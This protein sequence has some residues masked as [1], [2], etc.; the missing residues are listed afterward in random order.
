M[1]LTDKIIE[2]KNKGYE[3]TNILPIIPNGFLFADTLEKM[4]GYFYDELEDV[5]YPE[6]LPKRIIIPDFEDYDNESDWVKDIN[7]NGYNFLVLI[8]E[9]KEET[10]CATIHY[11]A[12]KEIENLSLPKKSKK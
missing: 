10:W 6:N 7:W 5:E 4:F 3:V 9:R 12:Y 1:K 11:Q 8:H 2:F